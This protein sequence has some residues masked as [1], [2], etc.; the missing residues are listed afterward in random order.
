[1][2][3]APSSIILTIL[4][5]AAVGCAREPSLDAA[6]KHLIAAKDAIRAGD[7]VQAMSELNAAIEARPDVWAYLERAKLNVQLGDDDAAKEDIENGLRLD[8]ENADLLW[9][10]NQMSKSKS[11]RFQGADANPPSNDK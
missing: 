5:L 4:V 1:M 3:V 11:R 2:D 7:N 9:L 10:Q 6:D 8:P